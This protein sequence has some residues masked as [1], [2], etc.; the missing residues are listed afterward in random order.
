MRGGRG[1]TEHLLAFQE[2]EGR[3]DGG[4]AVERG[5]EEVKGTTGSESKG[6][7][8]RAGSLSPGKGGARED[9]YSERGAGRWGSLMES[10]TQ[11]LVSL[12]T[13]WGWGLWVP[14]CGLC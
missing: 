3:D 8:P 9:G 13:R 12:G 10:S 14:R 5:S 4:G 7:T 6:R 11:R 1:R 2:G